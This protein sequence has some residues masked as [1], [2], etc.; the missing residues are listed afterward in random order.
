M[1]DRIVLTQA[2]SPAPADV[3]LWT[4][5]VQAIAEAAGAVGTLAALI[6]LGLQL[7][8]Q[9]RALGEQ[10]ESSIRGLE[11]VA[12]QIRLQVEQASHVAEQTR[13]QTEQTSILSQQ[14][15][16]VAMTNKSM[17]YQDLTREMQRITSVFLQR[18][19]LRRYFYD[20]VEVPAEGEEREEVAIM[21]EMFVDFISS[22]LNTNA[23]F[24]DRQRAV[25]INYFQQI[26]GSSPAIRDFWATHRH[27]YEPSVQ[28]VLD[29]V[30]CPPA[31]QADE[32]KIQASAD[33]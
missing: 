21:S 11:A 2:V 33:D 13:L 26:A 30:A 25:W 31:A 8:S 3:V 32:V 17:L 10:R 16:L 27:W 29:P 7:R 23:L 22:S 15:H 9:T 19:R 12:E 28:A 4:D 6:F 14:L 18:P 24:D 1:G 20:N 5:T